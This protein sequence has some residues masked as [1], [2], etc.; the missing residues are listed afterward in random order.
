[1]IDLMQFI[2]G[3]TV[4]PTVEAGSREPTC[5]PFPGSAAPDSTQCSS[6]SADKPAADSHSLPSLPEVGYF[7]WPKECL[8]SARRFGQADALLYPLLGRP[9]RTP[10][11]V[12]VLEQVLGGFAVVR[13]EGLATMKRFKASTVRPVTMTDDGGQE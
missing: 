6:A 7:R 10:Q 2:I 5:R 8:E 11:G 1:M 4:I 9:V 13:F 3:E 12:E